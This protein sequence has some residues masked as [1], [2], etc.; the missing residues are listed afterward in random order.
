MIVLAPFGITAIPV[1][2]AFLIAEGRWW[3]FQS[4]F[5][6]GKLKGAGS[7]PQGK[8]Q[9]LLWRTL[10]LPGLEIMFLF[11]WSRKIVYVLLEAEIA[12]DHFSVIHVLALKLT[13]FVWLSFY[14]F[15]L[16]SWNKR[17]LQ[18]PFFYLITS[19]SWNFDKSIYVTFMQYIMVILFACLLGL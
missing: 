15:W 8:Q 5:Q 13:C 3:I 12:F 14:G 6:F 2:V 1:K 17:N 19:M 4:S 16:G 7:N 9:L 10:Y 18:A 11:F